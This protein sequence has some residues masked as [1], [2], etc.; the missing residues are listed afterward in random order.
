MS[1]DTSPAALRALADA[2]TDE[3]G[4]WRV[5]DMADAL[6]AVADEKEAP[7]ASQWRTIDS[8]PKDGESV[9]VWSAAGGRDT[10]AYFCNG[11]WR[12]VTSDD[13]FATSHPPTHWMPLPGGPKP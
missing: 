12:V 5:N 8:A 6:R 2:W 4:R 13:T 7:E 9:D 1:I 11:Q 3:A 10:D